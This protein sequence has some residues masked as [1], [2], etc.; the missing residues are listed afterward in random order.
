MSPRE[1]RAIRNEGLFREVNSHIVDLE[2]RMHT[3]GGPLPLVCECSRTGCT[4]P[5]E[6]DPEVFEQVRQEGSL[7]FFV[8]PGHEQLDVES[9][10]EERD[11][12]L[13]VEKHAS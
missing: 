10:V 5:I 13:V 3:A 1:Q 6:V 4:Q 9:V 12:Y 11:G 7:R 8:A 2:E